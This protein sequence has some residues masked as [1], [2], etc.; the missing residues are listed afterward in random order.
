MSVPFTLPKKQQ[1]MKPKEGTRQ[2]EREEVKAQVKRVLTLGHDHFQFIFR[3]D[4][5]LSESNE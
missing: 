5:P 3:F 2:T 1:K 4:R